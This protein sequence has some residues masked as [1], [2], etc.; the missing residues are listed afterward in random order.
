MSWT[1]TLKLMAL[2]V[3]GVLSTTQSLSGHLVAAAQASQGEWQVIG[4]TV[5][6]FEYDG[7]SRMTRSF[8]NNEPE[9]PSDDATVTYAYD[10]LSRQVE[11]VQNDQAVSSRWMGDNNRIGLVYPNGRELD[12][13]FDK[14][15]RINTVKDK[16]ASKLIADYN[17]IGPARVLERTYANGVRL[18]YLDD[19][20]Q[21]DMG[22]DG[23]K[24]VVLHRHLRQDNSLIAGFGYGYD[25]ANNKL[26]EVK[27]HDNNQ[28]E[29]YTYDSIYRLVR[30][31]RQGEPEDTWQLDGVGNWAN[32]K[33]VPNQANN[34]NEYTTFAGTPQLYDDNGNLIDDG[35]NQYQ[36][37]FANRL[38]RVARKD[39]SVLLS[40]YT[41]DTYTANSRLTGGGRRVTRTVANDGS[42]LQAFVYHY[43]GVQE[44]EE[45]GTSLRQYVN[46][47]PIDE[48]I[49][50]DD[51]TGTF[52]YHN[53]GREHI[54]VLTGIAAD[55]AE[56]Y[57]YNS[58]G[59][60][61]KVSRE[62]SE[63]PYLFTGRRLDPETQYYYYRAR[64]YNP[65]TGRFIHR[66]PLGPLTDDASFLN[67]YSYIGNN[68]INR[69]DPFGLLNVEICYRPVDS[70]LGCALNHAYIRIGTWSAGFYSDSGGKVEQGE[71]EKGEGDRSEDPRE[72]YRNVRRGET[73]K[74]H[75][76]CKPAQ[77][78]LPQENI[79]KCTKK[80]NTTYYNRFWPEW[81]RKA[82]SCCSLTD[83]EIENCIKAKAKIDAA[84]SPSYSVSPLTPFTCGDWASRTL[85]YCCAQGGD[86]S[87]T[88][89]AGKGTSCP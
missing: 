51:D 81:V 11:E 82:I 28:S 73:Y 4:T 46:G 26:F 85:S 43:D 1:R 34:M 19:T 55:V 48:H 37:D 80:Y 87:I 68:P 53:D 16:G 77:R 15:D 36:Y 3:V 2:L 33:G 69:Y 50:L 56:T 70:V 52:F 18:T 49:A 88:S 32:R 5:Q 59:S 7:L 14:R 22:Y 60:L 8:D 66:D 31:A 58:Y 61:I 13:T 83:Q 38:R 76:T 10:S 72:P 41:Y 64:Y 62:P 78:C 63:N 35:T 54:R 17:Y 42:S 25:R 74:N 27:Q 20:R 9:D 29:D 89:R 67:L 79:C 84:H 24:R 86:V 75:V 23:L 47:L 45:A 40:I 71:R 6:E 12:Y 30:F 65:N 57:S 21:K 44:I 39:D